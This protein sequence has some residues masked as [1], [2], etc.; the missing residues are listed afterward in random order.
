MQ[1]RDL[2]TVYE[3][4][5]VRGVNGFEQYCEVLFMSIIDKKV[6]YPGRHVVPRIRDCATPVMRE[7][8]LQNKSYLDWLPYDRTEARAKMYLRAGRPF[9]VLTKDEKKRLKEVI[10]IRHAI[11][12]SSP[13]ATKQFRDVIKDKVL[14]PHEKTPSGYLRSQI[15]AT[16]IQRRIEAYITELGLMA[17]KIC[18]KPHP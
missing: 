3:S 2:A 18:G 6:T 14:L 8:L 1:L 4:L 13:H 15:S 5:F 16:P 9:T 10:T 17:T 11:A 12:H 7:L